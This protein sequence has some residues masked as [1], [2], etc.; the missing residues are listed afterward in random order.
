MK[1]FWAEARVVGQEG[2][3]GVTLDGRAVKLPSGAPLAVKSAALAT[4]IAAEWGALGQVFT[5]N[6]LPLTQLTSTALE[7]VGAH[8]ETIIGQLAAYGMNDLLCY[9]AETPPELVALE[10][11]KWGVWL[12]WL[13][14]THGIELETTAGL[15][16]I[17]QPAWAR[18]RFEA[19]LT[20]FSDEVIAGLGVIVPATGSLVLALALEAGRLDHER[21]CELAML[22]E[23][24]QERQWGRDEEAAKRRAQLGGD[25]AA[26]ARFMALSRG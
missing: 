23:L 7:R 25:V 12:K 3:F 2:R 22:D 13:A 11:E 6:D 10:E 18:E 26:A 1:R 8:R 14:R 20:A 19:I 9:R 21:A 16:P 15:T 4:G 24:W 17:D 5:P